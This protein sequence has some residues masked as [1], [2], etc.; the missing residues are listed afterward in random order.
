MTSTQLCMLELCLRSSRRPTFGQLVTFDDT[1]A[2][3][4]I[5]NE[6]HQLRLG[7]WLWLATPA[8]RQ[9]A[10]LFQGSADF[11]Q[12]FFCIAAWKV[13]QYAQQIDEA[14]DKAGL[15]NLIWA[16]KPY[17]RR[18]PCCHGRAL[19]MQTACSWQRS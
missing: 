5:F 6:P 12:H 3:L 9:A 10:F 7:G 16:P 11:V 18:H 19:S 1:T 8:V 13:G 14:T 4:L 15:V 2:N 17:D